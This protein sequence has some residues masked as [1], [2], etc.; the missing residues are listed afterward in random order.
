MKHTRFL[1]AVVDQMQE[2][3]ER[4][5][6]GSRRDHMTRFKGQEVA[7]ALW[8]LA[9]LNHPS[10]GLL[11][12]MEPFLV[13]TASNHNGGSIEEM[14]VSS[15][16]RS[17]VR[18]E[19]ANIAWVCAVFG[20]YPTKLLQLLYTGLL[21]VGERPDPN[22]LRQSFGD[23][24]I[25]SS[26][27]MSITYLQIVMD[28]ENKGKSDMFSLPDDFPENWDGS[29]NNN[30]RGGID[31]MMDIGS[32]EPLRLTSSNI[33][34]AVS[35][36]FS[37]IGFSHVEEHVIA[38]NTLATEHGIQ[39]AATG[40]EILSLDIAN[41]DSK[42]GIEVDGPG[43]FISNIDDHDIGSSAGHVSVINGKME[44]QFQWDSENQVIN[45]P[46]ALKLRI[47]KELG[48]RVI[49][50][51]FWEWYAMGGDKQK[52]EDFCRSVLNQYVKD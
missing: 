35:S 14:T 6:S 8:A 4:Y 44:Y 19:L 3:A 20:E 7:N 52:E 36:A 21:G 51:P 1:Q 5:V 43:H 17:F 47:L 42:I 27:I 46:T 37:R 16:S 2:R 32:F 25:Q 39:M 12:Q 10:P 18:Q 15:I 26:A 11:A 31:S 50:I 41:V 33:Q 30:G 23:A 22:Y 28:L 40:N 24:G 38:M 29:N 13:H 9:T 34:C 49:N 48:W 45:G